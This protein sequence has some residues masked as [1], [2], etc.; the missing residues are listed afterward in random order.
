MQKYSNQPAGKARS[1][2][3][4]DLAR[5]E[6]TGPSQDPEHRKMP[7]LR[8]TGSSRA[9]PGQQL[10][11]ARHAS[12]ISVFWQGVHMSYSYSGEGEYAA[13]AL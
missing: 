9:L 13:K 12:V 7:C 4:R 1:E 6:L 10:A 11:A 8:S 5:Y 2:K 3:M